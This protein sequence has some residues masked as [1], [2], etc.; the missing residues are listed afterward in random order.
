VPR[1]KRIRRAIQDVPRLVRL[2]SARHVI[3]TYTSG[4]VEPD[5]DR[6]RD[7]WFDD[8]VLAAGSTFK[9]ETLNNPRFERRSGSALVP[10]DISS[11]PLEIAAAILRRFCRSRE[12][13]NVS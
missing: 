13:E 6:Y 7:I 2:K 4:L 12:V 3:T 8:V 1:G 10:R 9:I 11:A 5:G